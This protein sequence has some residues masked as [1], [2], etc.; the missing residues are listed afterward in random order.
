[1]LVGVDPRRL[2]RARGL[3]SNVGTWLYARRTLEPTVVGAAAGDTAGGSAG[4]RYRPV[5]S[6]APQLGRR[7]LPWH[8]TAVLERPEHPARQFLGGQ[9]QRLVAHR[10][11]AGRLFRP[12]VRRHGT[13]SRRAG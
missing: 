10:P 4:R 5:R 2:P 8:H 9:P 7:R 11:V 3:A 6:M 1:R 12:V 13:P